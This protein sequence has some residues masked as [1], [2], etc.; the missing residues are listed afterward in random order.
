MTGSWSTS[1]TSQILVL[2]VLAYAIICGLLVWQG[3][4]GIEAI[5]WLLN[6]IIPLYAVRKGVE[7]GKNG[8]GHDEPSKP[9]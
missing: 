9:S 2:T 1:T 6:I 4:V 3:K 5:Q 8:N 7:A